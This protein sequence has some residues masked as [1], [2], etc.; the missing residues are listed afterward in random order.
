MTELH[1]APL[2]PPPDSPSADNLTARTAIRLLDAG[3]ILFLL[4]LWFLWF[5]QKKSAWRI[6]VIFFFSGWQT[7]LSLIALLGCRRSRKL[8][9]HAFISTGLV[10]AVSAGLYFGKLSVVLM[11]TAEAFVH[12]GLPLC[13]LI[14]GLGVFAVPYLLRHRIGWPLKIWLLVTVSLLTAEPLARV[15]E[16]S[17]SPHLELPRGFPDPPAGEIHIAAIG[18]SSTLGYPYQP[19]FGFPQVVAWRLEQLYPQRK[20]VLHNLAIAG[21]NFRQAVRE[22]NQLTVRPQ[23]L[24]IYSGHNEFYHEMVELSEDATPQLAAVDSWMEWSALFRLLNSRVTSWRS[25]TEFHTATDSYGDRAYISPHLYQTRLARFRSQCG[26]LDRF[27]ETQHITPIWFVPACSDSLFEPNRSRASQPFSPEDRALSQEAAEAMQAGE[28][29][30]AI[31]R[32]RRLSNKFPEFAEF[33]FR[34]ALGLEKTGNFAEAQ[35]H[36]AEAIDRDGHSLRTNRDYREAIRRTAQ[37]TNRPLVETG[38][39]LRGHTQDGILGAAFF[40]DNVHMTILG[41]YLTGIAGSKAIVRSGVLE[42]EF[43][44]PTDAKPLTLPQAIRRAGLDV[45]DLVKAY[46]RT[47]FSYAELEALAERRIA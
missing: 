16:F 29:D 46:R 30:L 20:I 4:V 45:A 9:M 22:L 28:T 14:A 17:H 1:P 7:L 6:D 36:F 26:Q 40:L 39:S 32:Y 24:L 41:Y 47:A 11:W 35:R 10:L 38:E 3:L 37:K 2:L 34:L 8:W 12:F 44:P 15:W 43:G 5:T 18:G 31:E 21:I 33:H 13:G 27:C 23:I 42:K 25:L 19:K